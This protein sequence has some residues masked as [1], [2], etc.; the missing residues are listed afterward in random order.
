MLDPQIW[1]IKDGNSNE[2]HSYQVTMRLIIPKKS[3]MQIYGNEKW[4]TEHLYQKIWFEMKSKYPPPASKIFWA[5]PRT[6]S[7][8]ANWYYLVL[9]VI[10]NNKKF[11]PRCR[12]R[13]R[14]VSVTAL[15]K[16]VEIIQILRLINVFNKHDV[17]G[18]FGGQF[19]G[20]FLNV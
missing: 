11:Y 16:K 10:T 7:G 9:S 12:Y 3:W 20:V 18:P 6:G 4:K 19:E 13:V 14:S 5:S 1:Q 17:Y 15:C 2:N 8:L